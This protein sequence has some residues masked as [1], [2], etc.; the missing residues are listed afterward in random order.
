MYLLMISRNVIMYF[1]YVY[2][3]IYIF[4]FL[5]ISPEGPSLTVQNIRLPTRG[6]DSK[7]KQ[8]NLCKNIGLDGD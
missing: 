7:P 8:P 3:F 1:L 2:I 6:A 4:C 5:L